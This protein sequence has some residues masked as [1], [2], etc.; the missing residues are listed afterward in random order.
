MSKIWAVTPTTFVDLKKNDPPTQ[1]T[2]VTQEGHSTTEAQPQ[3]EVQAQ[4]E[5]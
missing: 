4:V 2:Q 1:E 5:V 3:A